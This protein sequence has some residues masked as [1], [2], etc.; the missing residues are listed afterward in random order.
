MPWYIRQTPGQWLAAGWLVIALSGCGSLGDAAFLPQI[1]PV[2]TLP[3]LPTV[4]PAPPTPR[5]TAVPTA[6]PTTPQAAPTPVPIFGV[7]AISANVRAGPGVDFAIIGFQE[8]GG[9]V[10]LL[11]ESAGWYEIRLPD[12]ARGWIAGQLLV[13]DEAALQAVPTTTPEP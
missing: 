3:R 12:N 7:V 4:T 13:I 6:V 5:P 9:Q 11:S 1:S 10:E 2:P 8:Q